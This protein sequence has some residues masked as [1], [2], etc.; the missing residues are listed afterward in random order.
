M[1][2]FSHQTARLSAGRH[3]GPDD[4]VC[5]MELASILAGERFS[6]RPQ[7]V[8]S[9]IAAFMRGY[10]DGVDDSRRQTLKRFASATIGTVAT[11]TVEKRRRRHICLCI[12]AGDHGFGAWLSRAIIVGKEPYMAARAMG[13]RV[14]ASDDDR[15]HARML[16]L[17]EQLVAMGCA[18]AA[19]VDPDALLAASSRAAPPARP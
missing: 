7:A 8:S 11:R 16:E 19:S 18:D 17:V 1:E 14:A 5:V 3:T 13:E 6:D 10:N 9:S 15:L 4:G 12:G 2:T